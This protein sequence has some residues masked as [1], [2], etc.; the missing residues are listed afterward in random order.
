M[1]PYV[2]FPYAFPHALL[3]LFL[4]RDIFYFFLNINVC[5]L[6]QWYATYFLRPDNN[7]EL[8]ALKEKPKD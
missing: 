6:T 3:I 2:F 4:V 8:Q 7:R 5:L 1:L